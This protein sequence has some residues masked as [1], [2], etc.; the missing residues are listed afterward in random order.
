MSKLFMVDAYPVQ[1]YTADYNPIGYIYTKGY[2][3]DFV[4]KRAEISIIENPDATIR[5]G[6]KEDK[7][8]IL[9]QLREV[10]SVQIGDATIYY[11]IGKAGRSP[12]DR[13]L[14]YREISGIVNDKIFEWKT[15]KKYGVKQA[16]FSKGAFTYECNVKADGDAYIDVRYNK[17]SNYHK[18]VVTISRIEVKEASNESILEA[19]DEW[20]DEFMKD[21]VA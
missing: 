10:K 21:M 17:K 2:F 12:I 15:I 1:I 13:L 6:D 19:I 16:I 8:E 20:K 3:D 14:I 9:S 18:N 5:N 7:N 4:T 11:G